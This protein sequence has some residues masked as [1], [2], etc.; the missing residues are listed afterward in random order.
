MSTALSK[1]STSNQNAIAH[2]PWPFHVDPYQ[3]Y[4][5]VCGYDQRY[6]VSYKLFMPTYS[7]DHLSPTSALQLKY[8]QY[9]LRG[10][11]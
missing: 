6:S 5:K 1:L 9:T 10:Y 8:N 3:V 2:V 7:W 4:V 11:I